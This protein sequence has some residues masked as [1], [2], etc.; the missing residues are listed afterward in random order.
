MQLLADI[1]LK[2]ADGILDFNIV[3]KI[4][5]LSDPRMCLKSHPPQ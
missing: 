3:Q 4:Q 2:M 1:I 5:V